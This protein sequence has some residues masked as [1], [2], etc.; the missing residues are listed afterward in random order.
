MKVLFLLGLPTLVQ[1]EEPVV[2]HSEE[3]IVVRRWVDLS[4]ESGSAWDLRNQAVRAEMEGDL[5]LAMVLSRE[6]YVQRPRRAWLAYV[7]RLEDR[8]AERDAF[9]E[10][11]SVYDFSIDRR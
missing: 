1:W 9:A 7:E 2:G 5:E 11:E 8:A 3:V 4:A 10:L 6:A